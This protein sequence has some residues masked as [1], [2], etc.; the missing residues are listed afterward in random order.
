MQ[1]NSTRHVRA[2]T[3]ILVAAVVAFGAATGAASSETGTGPIVKAAGMGSD[4][5]LAQATC[6]RA[7]GRTSMVEIGSGPYCVNPWDEGDD[8]GGATAR[9]VTA[10]EVTVVVYVPNP[11]ML[12]AGTARGGSPPKDRATGQQVSPREVVESYVRIYR[13]AAES[14]TYQTWGRTPVFTLVEAS[15]SDEASQRADAV[16]VLAM[17][18]FIVIDWS[19][20]TTGAQVFAT[21]LAN[22][23]VIVMGVLDPDSTK[24]APY[25]WGN[26]DPLAL[27]YLIG[28]FLGTSLSG[29]KARWAGDALAGATRTFGIVFP[30]TGFDLASHER[31]LKR[32]GSSMAT[33]LSYDPLDTAAATETVPT[34][35]SRLKADGVTTVV[36]VAGGPM[37]TAL[38]K[39]AATQD[40]EPE[41]IYTGYQFQ[42]FD[43]FARGNEPDQMKHAFGLGVLPPL[44]ENVESATASDNDWY[45]G[46][47][48]G[49]DAAFGFNIQWVYTAMHY[50][51]P[52]LNAATV[53][54]GLFAVPAAGGARGGTAYFGTG[55][56]RT[57]GLPYDVYALLGTDRTLIW[58][59]PDI[60]GGAQA[61]P[62][63]VGQGKFMYLDDGSRYTFG[64]F[65]K[66][67][68]PFFDENKS[69]VEIPD[70]AFRPAG[71]PPARP[72]PC[73]GCPAS[74]A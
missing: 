19:D 43:G 26:Q 8:N 69:V 34:M 59:N 13:H 12:E 50:A 3:A 41:W 48:A 57:T 40:Y 10:T 11:Q 70:A 24:Q 56:G 61:A 45:Y 1:S 7:S 30:D 36:L 68:L 38:M 73:V 25:R 42:D 74:L 31:I 35:V 62:A 28:D 71:A 14:G 58:W 27:P 52:R 66:K 63:I 44:R 55:Y 29:K 21:Q 2:A 18:P 33:K 17:K 51:G 37:V 54:R 32:R 22:A 9:G 47:Q 67:D 46:P 49:I 39:A 15:G 65:P 5:A 20:P 6:D 60:S 64:D 53:Q 4:A 16:A 23:K 72:N